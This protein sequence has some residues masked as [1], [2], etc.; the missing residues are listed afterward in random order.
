MNFHRVGNSTF[1]SRHGVQ[2][3]YKCTTKMPTHATMLP[4]KIFH[5]FR[6]LYMTY[7]KRP[8]AEE[9]P[10]HTC[11]GTRNV[12]STARPPPPGGRGERCG[13]GYNNK[14]RTASTLSSPDI[15]SYP[16]E[17]VTWQLGSARTLGH[18]LIQLLTT[19]HTP[20]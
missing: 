15:R 11:P 3:N 4:Q 8:G 17:F 16:R 13:S 2:P 7:F 18:L 14:Y 1:F 6:T 12:E 19:S 20:R 10:P 9:D 5:L